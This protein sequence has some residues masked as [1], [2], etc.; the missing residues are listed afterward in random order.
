[1][2]LTG[3]LGA[4]AR[5]HVSLRQPTMAARLYAGSVEAPVAEA[6]IGL[7]PGDVQASLP[8]CQTH[9][10]RISKPFLSRALDTLADARPLVVILLMCVLLIP[11]LRWAMA[12]EHWGTRAGRWGG[13]DVPVAARIVAREQDLL[14]DPPGAQV[15]LDRPLR[16][17]GRL[18]NLR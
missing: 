9:N 14:P 4:P 11:W 12:R 5:L 13:A 3:P 8:K 10:N 2:Q 15:A 1:M 16:A 6:R 17:P 7:V 18:Q